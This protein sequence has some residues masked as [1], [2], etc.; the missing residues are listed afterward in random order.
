[1]KNIRNILL[2]ILICLLQGYAAF[3]AADA[4]DEGKLAR[5]LQRVVLSVDIEGNN[6]LPEEAILDEVELLT[7]ANNRTDITRL[8]TDLKT[9]FALGY[10]EQVELDIHEESSGIR[11]IFK[12]TENKPV[13]QIV[14]EG[15]TVYSQKKLLKLIDARPGQIMNYK[16][17]ETDI[18]KIDDYYQGSAYDMAHVEQS[19]FDQENGILIIRITEVEIED[20]IITGNQKT[21]DHVVL[22]EM[23]S[24]RGSIYNSLQLRKDRN[25]ILA[26]G[27]FSNVYPPE[28]R[29]GSDPSKVKLII[30]VREQKVNALNFGAGF[31]ET[32][33]WFFFVDLAFKNPF[34]TGEAIELKSQFS[35]EKQTYSAQYYH[36]WVFRSP[37]RFTAGVWN[38]YAKED[39]TLSGSTTANEIDVSRIGVST[40]FTYPL[41][42]DFQ[43]SLIFKSEAVNADSTWTGTENVTPTV[44]Y[45]NNSLAFAA[46]YSK[47]G[48]DQYNYVVRGTEL[49][50]KAEQGGDVLNI[51]NIGG[52]QFERYDLSV[53]HF[54][55]MFSPNDVLAVRFLGGIYLPRDRDL[56]VLEGEQYSV[57]GATT[58][59]GVV[60]PEL[61]D[62]GERMIIT[63]LEYRHTFF[64]FLQGVL[65]VDWADAFDQS[66][67]TSK[68]DLA[69]FR[70]GR[71]A[72]IRLTISGFT[73]RFDYGIVNRYVAVGDDFRHETESDGV[74]HFSLGQMF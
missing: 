58:L 73:I 50:F 48:H 32:E 3:A 24:K 21:N 22:R 74:I 4:L 61:I 13:K 51:L 17:L 60:D 70:I 53:T 72:G 33:P 31:S 64:D 55:S 39:L 42:D 43:V 26:L 9:I 30:L 38:T 12:V 52:V 41:T 40:K 28:L 8:E 36:P 29:P 16:I 63:N 1:M 15:N 14:M 35:Q 68:F 49:K 37:T 67:E 6:L 45:Q 19:N 18:K 65:F 71:G 57:G 2:L 34:R 54:M 25:R 5:Y 20:I 7:R 23:K 11:V 62:R 27:Y 59:R 44:N 69:R 10:F 47:L 56:P 66:T 46:I